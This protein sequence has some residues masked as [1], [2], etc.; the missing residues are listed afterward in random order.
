MA[1]LV[2][3]AAGAALGSSFGGV[4]AIL[5]RAAGA[6]AGYALDRAFLGGGGTA[7][8]GPRLSD[9]AVQGSTEGAVIPRLYGRTRLAGQMIW[10]TDFEEEAR[11]TTES[12]G[13]GGPSSTTT[14]YS[15]FANFAVALCEGSI[16]RIGRIWADG[17]PLDAS[18]FTFRLYSG[19][20]SQLPDSLIVAKQG[21]SAPAYRGT[22]Y[23]VF[24]RMPLAE[25][26]NRIPQ[27]SF[28]VFRPVAGIED[29]IRA[30]CVIPGSTEFGYDTM[31]VIR[32]IGGGSYKPENTHALRDVSDWTVSID[33]LQALC[34]NLEWVTLVV[35]WFGD[36]LRAGSCA[37]RPKVDDAGKD[38]SGADWRVAGLGRAAA[39][40]VS[41]VGGRAAYG[42]S[43][44]DRSVVRA[45]EDLKARGLKVVL[46]SFVLM[47]IAA[48]NSLPDPETGAN[49]QPAFPWRGRITCDPAPGRPGSPDKTAAV[50][51][52][53]GAFL[54]TAAPGDFSED[55]GEVSYS[56]PAEWRYR[57]M[58]LHYAHL[59]LLAG[60]VDGFLIGSEFCA[61]TTLRSAAGSYPFVAGLRTLAA[62]VRSVLGAAPQ[63]SYAADWT[64]Y[65]GHQPADGSSDV[66]FHLDPL[67]AD[68]NIDFIA[69]DNYHPLTD[70]R[71]ER[72]H[73]DEASGRSPYD[74]GYLIS[75][76]RGGEGFDWFY[77]SRANR[78]A[79]LR[80]AVTDG[81][82]GK[83]WV[84]RYKDIEAW[85][86][87]AHRD[88]P[89]GVEVSDPT[90][91][92]PRSKPIWF[93]ELGCPAVNKGGN[94][95]NVFF[96]PKSA[97]SA[98]PYFS[99]GGRDDLAQRRY[100]EAFQRFFD[101]E[102]PDFS[103]SNPLSPVYG[104]RM[105]PPAHLHLWAWDARP[106]PYF[107]ERDDVWSDGANW[108]R[109]HWLNGRLGV[110]SLD[111]LI[112]AILS[113]HGFSDYAISDVHALLGGY[114]VN[115]VLSARST[116]EPLLKAFR[117]DA[118]DAGER[119]LFR[120]RDRPRDAELAPDQLVEIADEPL[121]TRRRAQETELASELVL[122]FI[123]PGK[124][125]RISAA[126]SRRLGG[127]SRRSTS[128]DLTAVLDFAQAERLTDM[129]LRDIWTGR[130]RAELRLPPSASALDA[131]DVVALSG[132][133][134]EAFLAERIED[135]RSRNLQLRRVD[136][137]M[138]PAALKPKRGKR[139]DLAVPFGPPEVRIIDFAPPDGKDAHAP[140]MAAFAD[141]WPGAVAV[142]SG[143]TGGGFRLKAT[144]RR[145]A[146]MGR[147]V[148]PLAPGPLGL[149]DRG[150]VIDVALFG[151]TLAGL[152]EID[153]LAGGNAAAV[154]TAAGGWEILQFA[155]AELIGPNLYRL[156]KLLRGQC[157]SD[158]VMAAGAPAGADFVL[159]DRAVSPLPV[160]PDAIGSPLRY[161]FGPRRH[162]HAAP[163]FTERIVA[164]D[165]I[166]LKPFAPVHLTV[167]REAG[168]G[169]LDLEWTRRTR[170]GGDGWETAETPLNEHRERY[171]LDILDGATPRR[172]LDLSSP[173]Y[174]YTAADQGA[175]L[176]G[177]MPF[178]ARIRQ[179][180]VDVGPGYALE[181]I[182]DA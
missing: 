160:R 144:L 104:G 12:G 110:V 57:R 28:E 113:D 24:E 151:G 62:D 31:P 4:G 50:A 81:A 164:A 101:P 157:G 59:S 11:T 22:A 137:R 65:F 132:D 118:S 171:R 102:H 165:G 52:E 173:R 85:W 17:R 83:P 143:A 78:D 98:L 172:R 51:A 46:A 134:P 152:P 95:P 44:S 146:V 56:G 181:E 100:I 169:D 148:G 53:V 94:Q 115:E 93:T 179:L 129:A 69:I 92:Q 128:V 10:A 177:L 138:R 122:K 82:A 119:V 41:E 174:R 96:D 159:L 18:D 158:I 141:P 153:V 74:P 35:A 170:F 163:S 176:G 80:T 139:P 133:E 47:D 60:G 42:G 154:Q 79:Q 135:G 43:P 71:D 61:L 109:G 30:V 6:L 33:E 54:G 126:S 88:R 29:H 130:E 147:L 3:G 103:G 84:F 19:G 120:G 73:R 7:A 111:A 150:N 2:L 70:W 168:S 68:P 20:E 23:V 145:R 167:L 77:A 87:N 112:G 91:W 32:R 106:Y 142:Y 13:K 76:V 15:Y 64:E 48:G 45:I 55:D 86:S 39:E 90:A 107:P 124:D 123:D 116:L 37:I 34:P 21:G 108:E 27:L 63:V 25:F 161:R 131:G 105:V 5:G 72:G 67:W 16:A 166:G 75:N 97:Q 38:T 114:L 162:D 156:T 127:G 140:R 26:G 1:T 155:D 89:G 121:L 182:V 9:L 49:G 117:I 136:N 125:Y 180:S 149:F 36:D 99:D 58:V 175:D 40:T 178:T 8:Q 14:E 66:F